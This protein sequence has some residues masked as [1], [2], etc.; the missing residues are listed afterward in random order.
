MI[1][2]AKTV[3]MC[4]KTLNL[5]DYVVVR[6]TTGER[7]KGCRLRGFISEIWSHEKDSYPQAR[8]GKTPTDKNG[9]CFHNHDSIEEHKPASS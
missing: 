3:K 5:G 8:V 1:G 4:G 2:T 7:M 6:Y 9:W